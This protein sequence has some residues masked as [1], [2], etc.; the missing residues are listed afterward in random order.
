MFNPLRVPHPFPWCRVPLRRGLRP[1]SPNLHPRQH[2]FFISSTA[3]VLA[4][5]WKFIGSELTDV[6]QLNRTTRP[7]PMTSEHTAVPIVR[8]PRLSRGLVYNASLGPLEAACLLH[9]CRPWRR[10]R[11]T[12]WRHSCWLMHPCRPSLRN[13]YLGTGSIPAIGALL[14][15]IHREVPS[16]LHS[17]R[18]APEA[19]RSHLDVL[20]GLACGT[21]PDSGGRLPYSRKCRTLEASPA[22]PGDLPLY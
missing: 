2:H 3:P 13:A 8:Y 10:V 21:P 6:G 12:H 18:R 5:R 1:E 16:E 17:H 22:K 9:C 4:S 20:L 19:E 7:V 14:E 11:C 15:R